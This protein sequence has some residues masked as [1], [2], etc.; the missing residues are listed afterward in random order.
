MGTKAG[1]TKYIETPEKLLDLFKDYVK[2]EADNPMYKIEYVGK[3]GRIEKT[4][5]VTPITFEGFECYLFDKEI[6]RDLGDYSSNKDGR[7][8][9]YATI[10]THI[11]KHCFVY[12]FKGAAVKLFDPNLIARKLGIK[13]GQDVTTGGDKLNQPVTVTIVNGDGRTN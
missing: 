3:D 8:D 7:Y 6:I 9:A 12:N 11:Q 10:I 2:H 5:L 1:G 4:P 13:D